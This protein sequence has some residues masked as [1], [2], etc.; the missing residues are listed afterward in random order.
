MLL[1]SKLFGRISTS[2]KTKLPFGGKKQQQMATNAKEIEASER[3]TD[4]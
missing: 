4:T 1:G 3:K 2:D